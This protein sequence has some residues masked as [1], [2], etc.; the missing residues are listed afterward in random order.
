MLCRDRWGPEIHVHRP[1]VGDVAAPNCSLA[2]PT[3]WC[4]H[5]THAL[6]NWTRPTNDMTSNLT[7]GAMCIYIRLPASCIGINVISVS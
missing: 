3:V 7:Q 5:S 1:F 6:P 2:L 4:R